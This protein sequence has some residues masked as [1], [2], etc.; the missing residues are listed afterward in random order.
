MGHGAVVRLVAGFLLAGLAGHVPRGLAAQEVP[1]PVAV[2]IPILVKILNFDRNLADRAGGRLVV[3]VLFQSHYRTS[4]NV[5]HEVCRTLQELPAG[6]LGAM[7]LSCVAID[8]DATSA[9]DSALE[10]K[11]VQVLYVSPLRAVPLGDVTA[12]SRSAGITTLTGVPR[13]VETGLAIGLDMKG[14]R[15]EIVINLAASRA[16]GAD[17]TAHLLKLARVVGDESGRR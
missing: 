16:E 5:A 7:E 10:R 11:Q 6:A 14:E 9:L 2:Q 12:V 4:A 17:L 3:G 13:Y 15:P 1:V 8:L